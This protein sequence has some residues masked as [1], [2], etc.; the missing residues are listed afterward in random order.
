MIIIV[1]KQDKLVEEIRALLMAFFPKEKIVC[2]ENMPE[3]VE[4][5]DLHLEIGIEQSGV[6]FVLQKEKKWKYDISLDGDALTRKNEIKRALYLVLQEYTNKTLPWGSLTGIRPSKIAYALWERGFSEE[7][8]VL[9]LQKEYFASKEKSKLCTQTAKTEWDILKFLDLEN[10]YSLYISI[11][12]CPS[13]CFYCSFPAYLIL[14]WEKRLEEYFSCLI[15]ELEYI[16]QKFR[17]K[18]L[19]SVYVGGGTPTSVSAQYLELLCQ[20][21]RELF[22]F[23]EVKE[24]C[25]EAGR[26]D[27]INEEKLLVLKKYGVNRLSINPQSMKEET[28]QLIGRKHSV[29]EIYDSY[30]LAK[31]CGFEQINMDFILGLPNESIEDIA[32]SMSECKKMNPDSV[33]IHSLAWKRA[34]ILTIGQTYLNQFQDWQMHHSEK[35]MQMVHQAMQEMDCHPYYLYRQ[36]NMEGNLENVGYSKKGKESFYNML[37]M[38]EKHSILA[39]GAGASTKLVFFPENRIQRLENVKDVGHYIAR[40]E[41]MIQRKAQVLGNL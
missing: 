40:I 31:K 6:S 13:R 2:T 22:P 15:Q 41:E 21:I 28:L 3:K 14:Q 34:S 8:I 29:Q 30:F 24:F 12:F 23:E 18:K 27:T 38:E 19:Y 37:I 25:V 11:P 36:K 26:P 7:E 32:Y 33:T 17:H 10:S 1:M 4:K 20:K 39:A 35:T 9:H 16:A 5:N